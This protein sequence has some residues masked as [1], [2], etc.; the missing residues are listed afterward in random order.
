LER[1]A[2]TTPSWVRPGRRAVCGASVSPF[3]RMILSTRLL[4]MVGSLL[5]R[6]ILF[7]STVMRRYP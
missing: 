7:T 6:R 3:T 1:S 4:L 2:T 5:A